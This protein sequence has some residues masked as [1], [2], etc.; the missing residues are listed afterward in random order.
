MYKVK[1][2]FTQGMGWV[3]SEELIWG[4]SDHPWVKPAGRL[5]TA[6]PGA[7]KIPAFNDTPRQFNVNLYPAENPFAVHSSKVAAATT[8]Q[9]PRVVASP[10][11]V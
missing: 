5:L 7:Y 8:F 10:A 1:G 4:D 6:G 9:R 11:R 3:T 2:A